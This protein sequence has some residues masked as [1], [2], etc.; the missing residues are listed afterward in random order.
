MP[1][2]I[3]S[4]EHASNKIPR[5]Y[6]YL[7][8]NQHKL[9]ASHRGYDLGAGWLA[10]KMIDYFGCVGFFGD[11]SRLLV[12]LNRSLHHK[13]LYSFITKSFDSDEKQNVLTSFYYPYRNKVE[14]KI[15]QLINAGQQVIHISIHSFVPVLMGQER[16]NDVGLL[17]DTTRSSEK[18]FCQHWQ[19]NFKQHDSDLLVRSNYPYKGTA[20]G[21]T[22]YLR[23]IFSK[24][25]Y[26]GIELELNQKLLTKKGG[27]PSWL[28]ATVLESL[29]DTFVEKFM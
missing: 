10:E 29:E 11:Y 8:K 21:F 27:F 25:R 22:K 5:D 6:Q 2:L 4:C 26:V 7:F 13:N 9:L 28:V 24:T 19:R 14:K 18:Q 23:K 16:M 15:F 1:K 20:D 17:Y 12:D 3:V